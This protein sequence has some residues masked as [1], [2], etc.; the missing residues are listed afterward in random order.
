VREVLSGLAVANEFSVDSS[1]L[2]AQMVAQD[3]IETLQANTFRFFFLVVANLRSAPDTLDQVRVFGF[4]SR[5]VHRL[6]PFS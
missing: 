5:L 4:T 3:L 1:L 2:R 6:T